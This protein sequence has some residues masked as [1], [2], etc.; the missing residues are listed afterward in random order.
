MLDQLSKILSIQTAADGLPRNKG[1]YRILEIDPL[2]INE[3]SS[4]PRYWDYAFWAP[5]VSRV[6]PV[7]KCEIKEE[8]LAFF[9]RFRITEIDDGMSKKE[10]PELRL[11]SEE[12]AYHTIVDNITIDVAEGRCFIIRDWDRSKRAHRLFEIY[13]NR[14][15]EEE[16]IDFCRQF[17]IYCT[18]D[19]D[20][21]SWRMKNFL[22]L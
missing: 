11:S 13:S 9:D 17:W 4:R 20:G 18:G 15:W 12:E 16:F 14:E 19:D 3:P 7:M 6:E 22:I 5:W 1:E 21:V 8:V 10:F 2:K